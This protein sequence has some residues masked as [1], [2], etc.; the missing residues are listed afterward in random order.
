[1]ILSLQNFR[2]SRLLL[3]GFLLLLLGSV[4]L[5]GQE[6]GRVVFG[7]LVRV[8]PLASVEAG[9]LHR[10]LYGDLWRDLWS[11]EVE[12]PLLDR[13]LT[14]GG[15]REVG[16]G[17]YA[18][19]DGSWYRFRSITASRTEGFSETA[20]GLFSDDILNDLIAAQ[21]PAAPLILPPLRAAVGLHTANPRLVALSSDRIGFFE[22]L[23]EQ[24][25]IGTE[26]MLRRVR[27]GE[28][29]VDDIGYLKGRLVDLLVDDRTPVVERYR[30]VEEELYKEVIYRPIP[31]TGDL[32]LA[33][34]DGL[35][36]WSTE[37]V[38]GAVGGMEEEYRSLYAMNRSDEA[39]DRRF[40]SGMPRGVWEGVVDT[41]VGRLT[42]EVIDSA[43]GQMPTAFIV[44]EGERL[45]LLLKER[46]DQL[47]GVAS[48]L[49][50][51]LQ[52]AA[53]M[54]GT[55]R[56]ELVHIMWTGKDEMSVS[57]RPYGGSWIG[58]ATA[59]KSFR[60]EETEEI[61]LILL[62]GDDRVI[63]H[64]E[65]Q[66]DITLR[67]DGGEGSDEIVDKREGA[68]A[69]G[70]IWFYDHDRG[71]VAPPSVSVDRR[72]YPAWEGD[73]VLWNPP[74]RDHGSA[75]SISPW[76]G[77]DIDAGLLLGIGFQK[78]NYGFRHNP[79]ASQISFGAA[80]AFGNSAGKA[81]FSGVFR[82]LFANATLQTDLWFSELEILNYFGL[83]NETELVD[84][85]YRRRYYRITQRQLVA[86]GGLRIPRDG[87]FGFLVGLEG[88]YNRTKPEL[89]PILSDGA[90]E[91]LYGI[92][93]TF[94]GAITAGLDYDT[95]DSEMNPTE[96]FYLQA[97]GKLYPELLDNRQ[98]Y[99]RLQGEA[100]AYLSTTLL[101]PTTFAFRVAS[102]Q[103]IGT[104][105]PYFHAAYLG[106]P[107][108]MQSYDGSRFAGDRSFT[109]AAEIR[110]HLFNFQL[111][112]RF[113]VGLIGFLEGGR[114]FLDNES[115]TLWHY[116]YGGGLAFSTIVPKN[117]LAITAGISDELRVRYLVTL[118]YRF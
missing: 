13:G 37:L 78:T 31:A 88:S 98:T 69:E 32:A 7:G 34:F 101:R 10:S 35:V 75:W 9:G 33:R 82:D 51:M 99:V 25:P 80:Y 1:M 36:P 4:D 26:E 38:Y 58:P 114:V 28:G 68:C 84:S 24:N 79:F 54:W 42:D 73:S 94:L 112:S 50:D 102:E 62:G 115:S 39:L 47:K 56:P 52:P 110:A 45:A 93:R 111:I 96:G 48:D 72:E 81:E 83:G 113:G 103:V 109:G 107:S 21:H 77:Y 6:R 86:R 100:R 104:S 63:I 5:S 19:E 55:D 59:W 67:I 44:L 106:G 87:P 118:G 97:G 105:Y 95:R 23:P 90:G 40:L 16:D 116:G 76:L 57:I 61:R 49:Y 29:L 71:D 22:S 117:I 85:L 46:R 66:T 89:S 60:E 74:H 64:G 108:S 2:T 3:A 27:R 70:S 17:L 65:N 18:G 20:Q 11:A 8:V 41:V 12:V 91:G 30:W 15:L 43:V 53:E 92:E 14:G